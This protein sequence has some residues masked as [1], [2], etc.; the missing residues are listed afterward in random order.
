[1][2]EALKLAVEEGFR[3]TDYQEDYILKWRMYEIVTFDPLFWKA[4][5]KE[6]GW[7]SVN[8]A[9]NKCGIPFNGWKGHWHKFIE[10][11]S[12]GGTPDSFFTNLIE[13]R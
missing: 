6:L 2:K 1:M 5:G 13:K 10:H 7:T 3:T 4:V 11:L 12:E 8:T 9:C